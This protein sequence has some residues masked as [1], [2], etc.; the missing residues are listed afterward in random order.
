MCIAAKRL[1]R[2]AAGTGFQTIV[3]ARTSSVRTF[4]WIAVRT[5]VFRA[6]H[7]ICQNIYLV[8]GNDT[9]HIDYKDPSGTLV[10][11]TMQFNAFN[12]DGNPRALKL[13]VRAHDN[14]QDMTMIMH[15][16]A[17]GYW[18]HASLKVMYN[19][20]S[21]HGYDLHFRAT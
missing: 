8:L 17:N 4:S 18:H 9:H 21:I 11:Q 19:N 14:F 20:L 16:S 13:A 5:S 10:H 7:E 2:A 1:P 15:A 3:C 12:P 6:Q